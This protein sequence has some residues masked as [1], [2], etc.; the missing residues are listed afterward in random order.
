MS[1]IKDFEIAFKD[2]IQFAFN[3]KGYDCGCDS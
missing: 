3:R 2:A 1:E